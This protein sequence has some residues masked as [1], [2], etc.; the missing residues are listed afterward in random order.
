MN[1]IIYPLFVFFIRLA[2]I[3]YT[4]FLIVILILKTK[5]RVLWGLLFTY[6]LYIPYI[7]IFLEDDPFKLTYVRYIVHFFIFLGMLFYFKY[8][9]S[10]MTKKLN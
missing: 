7:I 6:V 1:T 3:L 8:E 10:N 9:V 4:S 2:F 5:F